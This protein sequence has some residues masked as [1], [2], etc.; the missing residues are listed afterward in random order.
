MLS[1]MAQIGYERHF[2]FSQLVL[3]ASTVFI[4]L[5]KTM[6]IWILFYFSPMVVDIAGVV[7]RYHN[8]TKDFSNGQRYT[9]HYNIVS[10]ISC[11]FLCKIKIQYLQISL[12][13]FLCKYSQTCIKRSPLG[14]RKNGLIRQVTS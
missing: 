14:H 6:L 1:I 4:Y 7:C 5:H 11:R 9:L 10:N 8:N 12:L 3:S 2:Y 13:V